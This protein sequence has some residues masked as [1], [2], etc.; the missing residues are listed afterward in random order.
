MF[1]SRQLSQVKFLLML[2][3]VHPEGNVANNALLHETLTV[4]R[5]SKPCKGLNVPSCLSSARKKLQS[6]K[7]QT[8]HRAR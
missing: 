4:S 6:E 3:D 2:K 7:A 1:S 8:Y 5:K